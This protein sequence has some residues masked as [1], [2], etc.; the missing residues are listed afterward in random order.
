MA[1]HEAIVEKDFR[2]CLILGTL[3]EELAGEAARAGFASEDDVVRYIQE[4]RTG[5][6]T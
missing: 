2:V 5:T 4:L 3:Q 1:V 6:G